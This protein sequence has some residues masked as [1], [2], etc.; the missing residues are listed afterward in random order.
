M[1][2]SVVVTCYK[3]PALLRLCLN[4]IKGSLLGFNSEIIVADSETGEETYDLMREEFSFVHF[5]PN[6][7]N[8]GFLALVNQGI[9]IAKGKYIF[10]ING[11]IIVKDKSIH[12][13]LNFIK[14][15][16]E[17]GIVAPRLINFDGSV[18]DSCFRFYTPMT[19]FYRRSFLKNFSFAKKHLDQF[20]MKKEK[21]T[22]DSID[23]DWVMGSAMMTSRAAIEKVGLMDKGYFMYF[24][25]VDWCWRFWENGYRVVY[26]PLAEVFHY[27]GRQSAS[28]NI[29]QSIL[30]NK[31]TRIHIRSAIRFF[32][33]NFGK[34]NPH[35]KYYQK[36][37]YNLK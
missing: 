3:N 21:M 32:L 37:N 36:R 16:P 2:L 12:Q 15:D 11:D 23:V 22:N 29:F 18:Q 35:L 17:I 4:S 26:Y 27:H 7:K 20:L 13:L 33:K 8:V 24:E 9:K 31:Y 1:E 6:K 10:I 30:F 28:K 14:K 34:M 25:D 5:I 19:I